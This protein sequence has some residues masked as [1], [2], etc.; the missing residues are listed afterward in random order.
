M[1][2]AALSQVLDD[3]QDGIAIFDME[4][5][6]VR[7]NKV[8]AAECRRL[9]GADIRPGISVLSLCEAYPQWAQQWLY[10]CKRALAGDSNTYVCSIPNVVPGGAHHRISFKPLYDQEGRVT[11]AFMMSRNVSHELAIYQDMLHANDHLH[12]VQAALDACALV[13]LLDSRARIMRVNEA[14]CQAT[15]LPAPA[16]VGLSFGQIISQIESACDIDDIWRTL[17]TGKNW[18]HEVAYNSADGSLIWVD[19]TV[20]P[21]ST[22]DG[23]SGY[24]VICFDITTR[25]RGN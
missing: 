14:F 6:F 2:D 13:A 15:G 12:Q 11:G 23:Q 4:C 19:A 3:I 5:R 25:K 21:F 8:F 16:L 10:H 22:S 24:L 1:N 18:H 9:Y 20:S 7:V 17:K